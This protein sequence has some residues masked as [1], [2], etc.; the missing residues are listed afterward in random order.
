M[1]D[2]FSHN[3]GKLLIYTH[4]G[5]QE[6]KKHAGIEGGGDKGVKREVLAKLF[7]PY[8][9]CESQEFTYFCS[10]VTLNQL[11][12]GRAMIKA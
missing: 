10:P 1:A 6:V 3:S 11:I 2:I 5:Q 7:W 9:T 4:C 12:V 8:F